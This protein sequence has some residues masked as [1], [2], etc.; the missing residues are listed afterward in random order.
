MVIAL[1]TRKAAEL[2]GPEP[3]EVTGKTMLAR[4]LSDMLYICLDLLIQE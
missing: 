2:L 1:S 4:L 3:A